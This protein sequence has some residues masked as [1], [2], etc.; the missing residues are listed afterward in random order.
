MIMI[1]LIRLNGYRYHRYVTVC[2]G[3]MFNN[4]SFSFSF[5]SVKYHCPRSYETPPDRKI[6]EDGIDQTPQRTG[7]PDTLSKRGMEGL[8]NY[9]VDRVGQANCLILQ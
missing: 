9:R 6:L 4:F 8:T 1:A 3:D 2:A 7:D 5:S